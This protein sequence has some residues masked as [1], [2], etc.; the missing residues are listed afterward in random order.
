MSSEIW[1]EMT[2][3]HQSFQ[4][5]TFIGRMKLEPQ[6]KLLECCC[7]T[8]CIAIFKAFSKTKRARRVYSR[9]DPGKV[10]NIVVHPLKI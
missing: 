1:G 9:C 6:N 3:R 8:I 10:E 2:S 7:N 5:L 4:F